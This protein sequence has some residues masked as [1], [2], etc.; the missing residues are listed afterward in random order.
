LYWEL[1]KCSG[2]VEI[3]SRGFDPDT[4]ILSLLSSRSTHIYAD[5]FIHNKNSRITTHF[6]TGIHAKVTLV[7][8]RVAYLGGVN[9]QFAPGGFSLNDLMYK[10]CDREEITRIRQQLSVSAF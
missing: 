3:Y 10:T 7:G 6:R 8:D 9:F 5:G 4:E 1:S 2:K